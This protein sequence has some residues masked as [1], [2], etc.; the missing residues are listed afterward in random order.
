MSRHRGLKYE[1]EDAY[2]EDNNEDG[3]DDYDEGLLSF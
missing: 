2:K 1:V 3:Y